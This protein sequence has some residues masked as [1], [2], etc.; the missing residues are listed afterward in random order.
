MLVC[1]CRLVD[2][3]ACECQQG[4]SNMM[5]DMGGEPCS[6]GKALPAVL[7]GSFPSLA[8]QFCCQA[9]RRSPDALLIT[10]TCDT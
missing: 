6:P 3:P 7:G 1:S 8:V 2:G 5:M 10:A 9:E 4:T